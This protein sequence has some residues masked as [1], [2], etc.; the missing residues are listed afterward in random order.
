M[1]D[2]AIGVH[3]NAVIAFP[4]GAEGEL[5]GLATAD[6][7]VRVARLAG[8]PARLDRG[9]VTIRRW[10]ERDHNIVRCTESDIGGHLS[11]IEAP[12]ALV[13]DV[14]AFFRPLR[15]DRLTVRRI[16]SSLLES[17]LFGRGKC[18]V[19][20]AFRSSRQGNSS[21][22]LSR[23]NRVPVAIGFTTLTSHTVIS[24]D[25]REGAC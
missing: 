24:R 6:G 7:R 16:P 4:V 21:R 25:L 23:S 8:R 22:Q 15:G 5:D 11:S 9:D 20:S 19:V 18:L 17:F 12:A 14:R 3:V 13:N 2:H 10:V 1:P